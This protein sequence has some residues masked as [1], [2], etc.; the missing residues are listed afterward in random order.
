MPLDGADH[1]VV[2]FLDAAT[3]T[4]TAR[5]T[6]DHPFILTQA[7]WG[8]IADGSFAGDAVPLLAELAA[9]LALAPKGFELI[10]AVE[11]AWSNAPQ[12][13]A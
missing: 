2:A 3:Q 12:A 10:Q 5:L 11:E 9:K 1:D 13:P 4:D 6:S 7:A 8:A